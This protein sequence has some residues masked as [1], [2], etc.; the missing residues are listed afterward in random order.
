MTIKD[1]IDSIQLYFDFINDLVDL[2]FV[3]LEN[4]NNL[5]DFYIGELVNHIILSIFF[6]SFSIRNIQSFGRILKKSPPIFPVS[7]LSFSLNN[8]KK[9]KIS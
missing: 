3:Y 4:L 5:N 9:F 6:L 1:I 8:H 7:I 2:G